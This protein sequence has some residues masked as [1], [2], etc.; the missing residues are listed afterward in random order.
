MI[1]IPKDQIVRGKQWRNGQVVMEVS[2]PFIAT[3]A[4]RQCDE[5][6]AAT[7][8]YLNVGETVD[9]KRA[10]LIKHPVIKGQPARKA[11]G[12]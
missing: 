2:G 11:Y 4:Q 3:T 8:A 1:Y 10:K 5:S 12:A 9:G 6:E 7:F